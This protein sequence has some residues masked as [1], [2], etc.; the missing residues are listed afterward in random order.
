[1]MIKNKTIVEWKTR[2]LGEIL[3]FKLLGRLLYETLDK[4]W[5]Q[6]II[7]ENVFDDVPFGENQEETRRGM[8][9]LKEWSN[10]NKAGLSEEAYDDLRAEYMRLF[11]GVNKV[12]APP[13]ESVYFNDERLVFQEQTLQVRKWY[14]RFGLEL[15]NLHKEPDDH[16]GLEM[17]FVAHLARLAIQALEDQDDEKFEQALENQRMFLSEHLLQWGPLWCALVQEHA[18]TDFYQ[19]LGHLTL[20]SLLAIADHYNLKIPKEVAR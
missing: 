8:D 16:I 7:E 3:L 19:G 17:M 20:G 11:V 10:S 14:R 15:E 18:K 5:L 12:L 1:M 13:W 4:D 2:L 9:L 6:N